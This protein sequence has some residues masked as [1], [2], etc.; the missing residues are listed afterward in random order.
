VP[1]TIHEAH[2]EFYRALGEIFHGDAA[3]MQALWS[4]ADDVTYMSPL[5]EI[6][7]GWGPVQASWIGQA[8]GLTGGPIRP[9][10]VRITS[11]DEL[12]V[13]VGFER[14]TIR[15]DGGDEVVVN[16]RATSTYRREGGDWK[17]IGHH[18]DRF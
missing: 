14:G 7:V 6:L 2:D 1:Q 8:A 4:H 5:G 18:T 9:D 17:M 13:I 11:A 16:L 3:P 10:D 15:I 12:G